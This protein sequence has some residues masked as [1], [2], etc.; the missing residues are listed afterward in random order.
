MKIMIS[1]ETLVETY[2]TKVTMNN[3][4]LVQVLHTVSY[5][6]YLN[7]SIR[8]IQVWC[9]AQKHTH[10][11]SGKSVRPLSLS[12]EMYW[13]MFPR[14]IQ[15]DTIHTYGSRIRL[16]MPRNGRIAGWRN[17]LHTMASHNSRWPMLGQ[18]VPSGKGTTHLLIPAPEYR[19]GSL[20]G[21]QFL[22]CD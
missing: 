6:V 13:R 8:E 16:L 22:D 21:S 5:L 4:F 1:Y 9:V 18:V 10:C 14:F 15:G 12:E 11:P 2:C 7:P 3:T 19:C 17:C 20:E